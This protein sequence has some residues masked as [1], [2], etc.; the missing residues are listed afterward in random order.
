MAQNILLSAGGTGGHFF[1]AVALAKSLVL[2]NKTIFL[3]TDKR[4]QNY[5]TDD[6]KD[7]TIVQN[8]T[9]YRKTPILFI[10]FAITLAF[11]IFKNLLFIKRNRIDTVVTF[12]GYQALAVL[13]PAFILKVPIILNEQNIIAGRTNRL[14][15]K[16]ATKITV[17]FRDQKGFEQF[18]KKVVFTGIPVRSEFYSVKEKSANEKLKILVIGGSQGAKFFSELTP[19]LLKNLS[20]QTLKKIDLVQQV[21]DDDRKD[22]EYNISGLPITKNIKAFFTDI[23]EEITNADIVISRSGASTI[24]ELIAAK[25][26]AVFIPYPHAMDNHQYYNAKTLEEMAVAKIFEEKN[27]DINSLQKFIELIVKDKSYL[28]DMIKNYTKNKYERPVALIGKIIDK[29]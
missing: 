15:A 8:V 10:K 7:F 9:R 25:K 2:E 27:L 13:I 6:I 5:I 26:P 23:A 28:N 24:A 19:K 21:K 12:G 1:P 17:G 20:T 11:F 14:F 18:N 3:T 16:I 29:L 22:F 4:C